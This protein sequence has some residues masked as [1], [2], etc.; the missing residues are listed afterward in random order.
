MRIA[1]CSGRVRLSLS[2][3]VVFCC[4]RSSVGETCL[5]ELCSLRLRHPLLG[6]HVSLRRTLTLLGMLEIAFQSIPCTC[7]GFYKKHHLRSHSRIPTFCH[8]LPKAASGDT[9]NVRALLAGIP[10]HRFR[11]R[12]GL[13]DNARRGVPGGAGGREGNDHRH[14]HPGRLCARDQVRR[15]NSVTGLRFWVCHYGRMRTFFSLLILHTYS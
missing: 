2:V 8:P 3:F 7:S 12:Q 1:V 9:P 5:E 10:V 13:S 6:H 4:L 14:E 15:S 11:F